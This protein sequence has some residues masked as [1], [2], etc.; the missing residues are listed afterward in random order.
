MVKKPGRIGTNPRDACV[1]FLAREGKTLVG[2]L[3]GQVLPQPS[4]HRSTVRSTYK[5]RNDRT[6][7]RVSKQ[8]CNAS[9]K[10]Q[11]CY[12]C[13]TMI[14]APLQSR[15]TWCLVM[16]CVLAAGVSSPFWRAHGRL[17]VTRQPDQKPLKPPV[18]RNSP[19]QG[20]AVQ[21]TA[22]GRGPSLAQP[23]PAQQLC[24]SLHKRK[25]KRR[26]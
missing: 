14:C 3:F 16:A 18:T 26:S 10:T 1:F 20:V 21:R 23:S 7:A 15:Y 4:E 9:S 24:L 8:T 5:M 6:R 13:C 17:S 2:C 12:Y 25:K 19:S 22:C 11:P